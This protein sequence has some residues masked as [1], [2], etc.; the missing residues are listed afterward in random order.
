[1]TGLRV[2]LLTAATVIAA[3]T[4]WSP[5]PPT[6]EPQPITAVFNPT[7]LP[8]YRLSPSQVSPHLIQIDAFSNSGNGPAPTVNPHL[9]PQPDTTPPDKSDPASE[10]KLSKVILYYFCGD[11]IA[12]LQFFTNAHGDIKLRTLSR[13]DYSD[14]ADYLKELA[15]FETQAKLPSTPIYAMELNN[16]CVRT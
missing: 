16:N 5:T 13:W 2:L 12:M 11:N 7:P 4:I 1:M 6:T 15:Y 9:Q 10:F 8:V 3:Y 14:T